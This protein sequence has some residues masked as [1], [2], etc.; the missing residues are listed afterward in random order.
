[1]TKSPIWRCRWKL[2]TN[3]EYVPAKVTIGIFIPHEY[4]LSFLNII[5]L[6]LCIMYENPPPIFGS[7]GGY[8]RALSRDGH[9]WA[10]N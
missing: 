8:W 5:V 10:G 9:K 4:L 1:M 6:S 3:V 7:G 2:T